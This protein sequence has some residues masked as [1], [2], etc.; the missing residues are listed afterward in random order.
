MKE[1]ESADGGEDWKSKYNDLRSIVSDKWNEVDTMQQDSATVD[2]SKLVLMLH[3]IYSKAFT[4]QREASHEDYVR[5]GST[6]PPTNR[7][8]DLD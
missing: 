7:T 8:E 3:E 4:L 1:D 6:P 5:L 2:A